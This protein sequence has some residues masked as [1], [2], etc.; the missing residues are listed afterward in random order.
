MRL[1]LAAKETSPVAPEIAALFPWISNIP[2]VKGEKGSFTCEKPLKA[3]LLFSGG[4][5]PGGHNVA[6]ALFDGLKALHPES[7]LFGFLDGPKGLISGARKE[8][9]EKDLSF[10]RNQGGFDLLGSSRTKIE[11]KE[12][13]Q[14]ALAAVKDLDGLVIVGGDD[15]NTNAALLADYFLQEKCKTAVVGVP[16]T[17]D[18]DLQNAYVALS[19]GFDTACK[20]YSEEIGNIARDAASAKKY[21]HFIKLMG[22][23]ASH[24]VL[25]CALQTHPNLAFIG[26]ERKGAEEIV[27]AICRVI[28]ARAKAGKNYGV[29]LIPEGLAEFMPQVPKEFL[30]K[31][32][33]KDEHGNVALSAIETELL[34][35]EA[36][37]KRLPQEI[38]FQPLRHFLGYEGR[39]AL[40]SNFDANY[41]YAL[42]RV[43]ALLIASGKTGYMAFVGGLAQPPES[44]EVGGVPLA[45]LLRL[46]ERKGKKKPVIAKTF[47]NLNGTLYRKFCEERQ[48]WEMKDDCRMPGPI[49]YFGDRSLTDALPLTLAL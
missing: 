32:A 45:S 20:V 34:L 27:S 6:A 26:E 29:I 19:F 1:C 33:P 21:T 35:I 38:P 46:E 40:P 39:S 25:E 30:P 3:A 14:K 15:S 28:V 36:V 37:K 43:G 48:A 41:A 11:T 42:G 24:I 17:I 44:W 12:Q 18:G 9:V 4:P 2:V 7:R 23:S 31:D 22:R 10:F 47:V 13:L 16:K 49:Q 8:L 5:A